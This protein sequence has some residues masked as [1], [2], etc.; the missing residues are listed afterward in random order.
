LFKVHHIS[1]FFHSAK[2]PTAITDTQA[3]GILL[4]GDAAKQKKGWLGQ[5][6]RGFSVLWRFGLLSLAV[7]YSFRLAF[8]DEVLLG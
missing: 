5:G 4:S 8:T 2:R 1:L 3:F 6:H 7:E